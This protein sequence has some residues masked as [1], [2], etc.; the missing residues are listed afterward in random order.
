MMNVRLISAKE[1]H[2]VMVGTATHENK[3]IA[4]PVRHAEAQDMLVKID[5]LLNVR[6]EER[7][8]P[9]LQWTNPGD[10]SMTRDRFPFIEEFNRG[11]LRIGEGQRLWRTRERVASQVEFNALICERFC[12]LAKIRISRNFERLL[13][14]IGAIGFHE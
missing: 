8:V 3:E 14:A 9:D 2:R 1:I 6:Y 4:N 11:A 10:V 5:D 7:D 13:A 12:N